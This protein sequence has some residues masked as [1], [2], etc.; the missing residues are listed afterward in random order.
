L[1]K[2]RKILKNSK[3]SNI[4]ASLRINRKLVISEPTNTELKIIILKLRSYKLLTL[5]SNSN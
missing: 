5:K 4:K 3:D 2:L 1:R